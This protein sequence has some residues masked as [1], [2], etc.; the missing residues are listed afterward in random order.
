MSS[1]PGQKQRK[2]SV[3]GSFYVLGETGHSGA[4]SVLTENAGQ[5]KVYWALVPRRCGSSSWSHCGAMPHLNPCEPVTLCA[6][7][8][9]PCYRRSSFP[10]VIM[11]ISMATPS[12]C[13]PLGDTDS[14]SP[15][16]P[17]P[18]LPTWDPP[19]DSGDQNLQEGGWALGPRTLGLDGRMSGW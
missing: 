7:I 18:V 10:R 3:L 17:V 5:R 12:R 19:T 13:R 16:T 6:P 15:P 11:S 9:S 4:N 8:F 2:K 1:I 14:P